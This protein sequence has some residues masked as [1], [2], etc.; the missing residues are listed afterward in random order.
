MSCLLSRV[1]FE[2]ICI[3]LHNFWLI[4][5]AC[6][7]S[8][9]KLRVDFYLSASTYTS[10]PAFGTVFSC[11][12][13]LVDPPLGTH[14]SKHAVVGVHGCKRMVT[15]WIVAVPLGSFRGVVART[16]FLYLF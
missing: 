12:S 7:A 6:V 1:P 14:R 11:I 10:A 8:L 9:V 13:S 16:A 15:W 3:Y 4:G 2:V 5:L